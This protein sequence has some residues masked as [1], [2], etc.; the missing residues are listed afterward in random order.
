MRPRVPTPAPA[1]YVAAGHPSPPAPTIRID[2]ALSL[3]WPKGAGVYQF[4]HTS[5]SWIKE[6][7]F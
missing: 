4:P 5:V 3:S 7:T 6:G 2:A 1:R